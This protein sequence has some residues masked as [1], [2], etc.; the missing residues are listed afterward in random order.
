LTVLEPSNML[1]GCIQTIEHL[2]GVA[3]QAH[4]TPLATFLTGLQ[5]FISLILERRIVIPS[6]RVQAVEIRIRA[7][8]DTIEEWIKAGERERDAMCGLLPAA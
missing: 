4:V 3:T 6:Q 7:V 5:S 8:V 1:G 2:Q